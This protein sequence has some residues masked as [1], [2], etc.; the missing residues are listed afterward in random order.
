MQLASVRRSLVFF[1]SAARDDPQHVVRQ[2]ALQSLASSQGARIQA[3][4]SL[5]VV[6]ITGIG[7][8][9]RK[10]S[11]MAAYSAST[12]TPIQFAS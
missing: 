6:N 9:T 5:S 1:I 4:R 11:R 3:S 8:G 10:R 12:L 7:D 2:R